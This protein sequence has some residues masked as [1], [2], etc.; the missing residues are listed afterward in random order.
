MDISLEVHHFLRRDEARKWE[1]EREKRCSEIGTHR[2][3]AI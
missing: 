3:H 2:D 1:K